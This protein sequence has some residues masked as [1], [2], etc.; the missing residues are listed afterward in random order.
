MDYTLAN[1]VYLGVLLTHA[2]LA[3]GVQSNLYGWTIQER[4]CL[5]SY[6]P[7]A[8]IYEVSLSTLFLPVPLA[9]QILKTFF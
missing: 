8:H 9:I 3:M 2:Q 5:L 4:G 1:N 6:L 7:L